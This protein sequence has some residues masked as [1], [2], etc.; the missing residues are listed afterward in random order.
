MHR[1]GYIAFLDADDLWDSRFLE[2]LLARV[3][4]G[5]EVLYSRTM[6]L[7]ES[8]D[9]AS[10]KA[11]GG[12]EGYFES[13]CDPKSGEWRMPLQTSAVMVRKRLLDDNN[14]RFTPEFK[15]YEDCCVFLKLTCLAPIC[16]VDEFLSYYRVRVSST[17]HRPWRP[18]IHVARVRMWA[19]AEPFMRRHRPEQSEI[20]YR[21]YD[22]NAYRY[23][24]L[25]LKNGFVGEARSAIEEYRE[26]LQRFIHGTGRLNNRLKCWLMLK[27][28]NS[29]SLLKCLA[30][31]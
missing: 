4:E 20:F 3:S 5:A 19:E 25:A 11:S 30:R 17:A 27:L 29:D 2:K 16:C 10:H 8:Q 18:E 14:I 13:F 15:N 12:G 24:V 23:I 21:M 6:Q 31:L 22:F 7:W 26:H 28:I 1:G 9:W